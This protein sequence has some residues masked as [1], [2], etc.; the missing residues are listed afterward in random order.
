MV[1]KILIHYLPLRGKEI[2]LE[3]VKLTENDTYF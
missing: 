1:F 3:V 2:S